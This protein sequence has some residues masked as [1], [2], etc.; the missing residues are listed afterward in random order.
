MST[1]EFKL[2]N[3]NKPS[4]HN[5]IKFKIR[6]LKTLSDF[7][8]HTT[9]TNSLNQKTAVNL[10]GC[11]N[12]VHVFVSHYEDIG[13]KEVLSLSFP[14]NKVFRLPQNI[15]FFRIIIQ[16]FHKHNRKFSLFYHVSV[17]KKTLNYYLK[18]FMF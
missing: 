2:L 12:V 6:G 8:N 4:S 15:I 3:L 7:S 16:C 1:D 9:L 14:T 5:K 17:H 13:Y 11:K 18:S 10:H